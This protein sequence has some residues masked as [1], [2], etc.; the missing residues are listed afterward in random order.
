[1]KKFV[2]S[3]LVFAMLLCS[4]CALSAC[5]ASIT[6]TPPL[7]LRTIEKNLKNQ[8]Y[9]VYYDN[10]AQDYAVEESLSAYAGYDT[11]LHIYKFEKITT[12]KYYYDYLKL[13]IDQEIQCL[14]T[15]LKLQ[16]HLL[17]TYKDQM[18][19]NEIEEIEDEIKDLEKEIDEYKNEYV[20]GWFGNYVW[21]GSPNAIDDSW[22]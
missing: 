8:N 13:E 16:K 4:V 12:A 1:M 5:S 9:S 2:S 6:D 21:Y 17:S 15:E 22:R 14:E 3:L 18:K 11:F 19:H 10:D 20:V 7:D